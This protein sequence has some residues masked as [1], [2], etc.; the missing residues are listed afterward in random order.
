MGEGG[1]E[2]AEE[3]AEAAERTLR[4]EERAEELAEGE[5]ARWRFQ[6]W[7][8][9]A[10]AQSKIARQDSFERPVTIGEWRK[11][12]REPGQREQEDMGAEADGRWRERGTGGRK[13]R[14]GVTSASH[15][16]RTEEG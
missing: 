14:R 3:V 13:E 8:M 4:W 9:V 10:G 5:W 6:L 12:G 7:N 15:G 2:G 1:G 16:R 11:L